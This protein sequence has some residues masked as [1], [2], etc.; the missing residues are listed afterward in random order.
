MK[1]GELSSVQLPRS[2]SIGARWNGLKVA[3]RD[4]RRQ[5]SSSAARAAVAAAVRHAVGE[6]RGVHRPGRGAG[7]RL[8]L[9]PGLLE[10][11]V[12]HAPGEGAVR[13]A[14]LQRQV[15]QHRR[16]RPRRRPVVRPSR[17]PAAQDRARA[18]GHPA[19]G[20][21][22]AR[23]AGSRRQRRPR[24]RVRAMVAVPRECR[25]ITAM[26]RLRSQGDACAPR[27]RGP[28]PA[29]AADA[30]PWI[31]TRQDRNQSMPARTAPRS[32]PAPAV[33]AAGCPAACGALAVVLGGRADPRA[34]SASPPR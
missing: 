19:D 10:Q 33:A 14:A 3:A 9:D 17:S 22:L 13:P 7:D 20:D 27:P 1:T 34:R 16:P 32:R 23:S 8:D 11:P 31:A 26:P 4:T 5:K 21:A 15:H 18:P 2:R 29:A 30:K 25:R 28:F 24:H 6:D 12:E